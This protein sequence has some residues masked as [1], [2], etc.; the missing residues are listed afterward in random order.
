M[1]TRE[2][3]TWQPIVYEL[4]LL[5]E[6]VPNLKAAFDEAIQTAAAQKVPSIAAIKTLDD[7]L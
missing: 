5:L 3:P 4:L 6:N 7:Y 2:E 1:P